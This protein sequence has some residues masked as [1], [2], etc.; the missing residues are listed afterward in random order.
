MQ[1][2]FVSSEANPHLV[3]FLLVGLEMTMGQHS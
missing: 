1:G 3:R 2:L